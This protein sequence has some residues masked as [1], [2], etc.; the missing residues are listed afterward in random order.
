MATEA[1]HEFTDA[2]FED[3]VLKSDKPVLVDFWAVWCGPC[4]RVAPIVE[5]LAKENEGK[6]VIGKVDVDNNPGVAG[7][8]G[9]MSIPTLII[10][11]DGQEAER[12]VGA[13][14]KSQ[15]QSALDKYIS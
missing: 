7:D 1:V 12:L 2:T 13:L 11:K 14:P 15:L 4:Q 9:V 5:E 8:F 3:Q 6:A 10:F